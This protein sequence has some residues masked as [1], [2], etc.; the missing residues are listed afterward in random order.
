MATPGTQDMKMDP[1]SLYREDIYTDRRM[2]TIRVMTPVTADGGAD[3]SRDVIF[4]GEAQ[5]LTPMGAIPLAFEL[6]AQTLGEAIAKFGDAAQLAVERT[7]REL[8]EMRR[9]QASSIVVPGA[10][11]GGMGGLGGGGLGGLGGGGK[12]QMP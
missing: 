3:P 8:R 6:E 10:G 7:A 11:M 1:A 4:V 12:I 5:V 9:E 2:G